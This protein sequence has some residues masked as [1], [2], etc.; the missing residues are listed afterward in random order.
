[1]KAV[2][3]GSM[4]RRGPVVVGVPTTDTFTDDIDWIAVER[5]VAGDLPLPVL[6]GGEVSA[7]AVLLCSS[8]MS[9]VDAAVL[10][11]VDKG[12]VARWKARVRRG[13]S[14]DELSRRGAKCGTRSG[15]KRH[16]RE[17]TLTCDACRAAKRDAERIRR[18]VERDNTTT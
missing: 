14:L 9:E 2:A 7:A 11:G 10:L 1:M 15:Y 16:L 13:V 4:V 18:L 6:S 5:F 17:G 8:G 3:F 12:Q